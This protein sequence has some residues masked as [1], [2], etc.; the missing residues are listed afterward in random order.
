MIYGNKK[1]K[2]NE[3]PKEEFL[4]ENPIINEM[5]INEESDYNE[6]QGQPMTEESDI[7]KEDKSKE[8]KVEDLSPDEFRL[9]QRTGMIP[10]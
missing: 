10:K 8:K 3:E 9:Y 5:S 7:K 6:P 1:D 2:E 4:G